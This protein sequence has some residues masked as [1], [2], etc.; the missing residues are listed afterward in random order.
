MASSEALMRDPCL[1]G[2]PEMLTVIAHVEFSTKAF[3]ESHVVDS[4]VSGLEVR[5]VNE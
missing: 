2:L 4:F 1:L 3:I 5:G